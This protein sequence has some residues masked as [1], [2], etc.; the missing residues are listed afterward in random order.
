[1]AITTDNTKVKIIF[2]INNTHRGIVRC[3][4]K[5]ENFF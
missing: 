3:E 2:L 4:Q 1:M 5:Q